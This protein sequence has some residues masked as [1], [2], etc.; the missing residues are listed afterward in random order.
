MN[1]T[2][3]Q[4]VDELKKFAPDLGD[5]GGAERALQWPDGKLLG[6]LLAEQDDAILAAALR[7]GVCRNEIIVELLV[8]RHREKLVRLLRAVGADEHTAENLVQELCAKVLQGALNNFDANQEFGRYLQTIVRNQYRS[9]ARKRQPVFT[10]DML[11]CLGPDTV[12]QEVEMHEMLHRFDAAIRCLPELE[13][14]IMR[15]TCDG[16]T[17]RDIA[18]ELGM[19]VSRIY[20]LLASCRKYLTQLL[21]PTLTASSRGRPRLCRDTDSSCSSDSSDQS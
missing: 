5:E 4:F 19:E 21:A 7:Y 18:N 20:P 14:G 17:P 3:E 15:M 6:D 12:D 2:V 9:T 11:G 1:R 8:V 10:E 16:W 13:Q